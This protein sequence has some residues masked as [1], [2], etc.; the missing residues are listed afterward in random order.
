MW[1]LM[2]LGFVARSRCEV[3]CGGCFGMSVFGCCA[4]VVMLFC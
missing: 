3:V 2:V 1:F 4:V